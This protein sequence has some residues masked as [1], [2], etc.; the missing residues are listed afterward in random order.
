M[1]V[2]SRQGRRL[3]NDARAAIADTA[4]ELTWTDQAISAYRGQTRGKQL[5]EDERLDA[6]SFPQERVVNVGYSLREA[7]LKVAEASARYP[8]A[9]RRISVQH[10][11]NATAVSAVE[12]EM[13]DL[14]RRAVADGVS[15]SEVDQLEYNV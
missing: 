4:K 11:V 5:S 6:L 7:S 3:V 9:T 8:R 14:K 2:I 12:W 13:K 10:L 1:V 15:K